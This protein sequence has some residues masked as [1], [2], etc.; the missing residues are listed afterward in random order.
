[1]KK[2][3]FV[4]FNEKVPKIKCDIKNLIEYKKEEDKDEVIPL[5]NKKQFWGPIRMTT[6][7]RNRI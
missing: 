6:V 1:M 2:K 4:F 3:T 5:F 7:D